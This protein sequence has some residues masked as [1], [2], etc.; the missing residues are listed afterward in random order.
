MTL[1]TGGI[2]AVAALIV[3]RR[4][5]MER[6]RQHRLEQLRKMARDID[7]ARERMLAVRAA[8]QL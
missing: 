5:R 6:E 4:L 3:L 1:I 7:E 8:K 2:L